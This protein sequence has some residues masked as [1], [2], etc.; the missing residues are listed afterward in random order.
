MVLRSF[1]LPQKGKNAAEILYLPMVLAIGDGASYGCIRTELSGCLEAK[2]S[3]LHLSL[4]GRPAQ[5]GRAIS[6][7]VS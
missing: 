1:G 6:P 3:G 5:F 4:M 7:P 2:S